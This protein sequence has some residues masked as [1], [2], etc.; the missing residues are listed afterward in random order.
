[1]GDLGPPF[2]HARKN[3]TDV[4]VR[5]ALLV[6]NGEGGGVICIAAHGR[7]SKYKLLDIPQSYTQ[8]Y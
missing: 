7:E 5:T 2:A 4:S 8:Y 1:M 3:Q 6:K